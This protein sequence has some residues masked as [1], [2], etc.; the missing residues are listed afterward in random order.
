[1]KAGHRIGLIVASSNVVWALPGQPG[2][3]VTVLGGSTLELPSAPLVSKQAG[4]PGQRAC[5]ST[6]SE[7]PSRPANSSTRTRASG[8]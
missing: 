8:A 3:G 7:P 1:M 2:A 4:R 6:S 5:T